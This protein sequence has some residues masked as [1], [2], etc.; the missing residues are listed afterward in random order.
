MNRNIQQA[1]L[2]RWQEATEIPPQTIGPLTP[3]Y[4]EVTKRLK[5][6]PFP[7]LIGVSIIVV[8]GILYILGASITTYVSLLQRGF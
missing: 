6:I 2:N 7:V 1:F 5:R 3:L 4:K 8:L